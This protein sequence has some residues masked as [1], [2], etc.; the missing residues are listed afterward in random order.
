MLNPTEPGRRPA[1]ARSRN[2]SAAPAAGADADRG[3]YRYPTIYGD[4]LVFVCEDDLWSVPT[5]GGTARRLVTGPGTASFPAFS[6]D[7]RWLVYTSTDDGPAEAYLVP[8]EGGTPRRLSYFGTTTQSVGWRPDGRS[9]VVTSNWRLP[10]ARSFQLWELPTGGAPPRALPV[11]PARAISYQPDGPGVVIGRNSGDPAR[12]KRYRGGT[13]GTLWVDRNGDG[14]FAPLIKLA[15]NLAS[16][17]WLGRRI[18]FL[19]D[20][21]GHGNLYS[22]TPTGRGLK[23]HTDHEDYYVRFPSTDGRRIAYHRGADLHVFDP[24]TDGCHQVDVRTLS[25]RHG[26]GRRFV[27]AGRFLE[28]YDLHP[29]GHSV[30]VVSRGGVYT[31]PLWEGAAVCVGHGADARHRLARWLPDGRHVLAVTDTTGEETLVKLDATGRVAPGATVASDFGRAI[32][33]EVDPQGKFAALTNERFELYL[34]DLKRKRATLIE[35]SEYDRIDGL[36]WSPDG[37]WL[38]YGFYTS[39]RCA[40]LHLLDTRTRATRAITSPGF[41]DLNPAFDPDGKYLYFLSWR[42][43]DPV[44]D[45]HYFDLGFPRGVKP[46]LIPLTRSE[47]SPFDDAA[48]VPRA[49][50]PD[51]GDEPRPGEPPPEPRDADSKDG[52]VAR[53]AIDLAGIE[54]RVVSFPALDGLYEQVAG[55]RGQALF[56][57]FPVEGS[58]DLTW[59]ETEPSADGFLES[60]DYDRQRS[61]LVVD[62]V[63]DFRLAMNAPV[64]AVRSGNRLRVVHANSR[65]DRRPDRDEA[66]RETGW[67]DLGRLRVE[68]Q[69]PAEWRQMFDEAWRLQRDHFWTEDMSK[70]DWQEVRERYRPLLARVTTRSEFSD[71]MWELQGELG[72]SHCYELGGDY[73]PQP[74]WFQ[75]F[76]GADLELNDGTWVIERL[77]RG[78]SWEPKQSSPLSAPGLGIEEGDELLAIDGRPVDAEHSPYERLVNLAG[79]EL[80]LV[81]RTGAGSR[82]KGKGKARAKGARAPRVVAVTALKDETPLRYRDWVECKRDYVHERSNGRVGYVHIPNMGPVG[83]AEFHRY[84]L[85]EVDRDALL[86]DVRWNGG[87]HVSQLLLEKLLR[88]PIGWDKPRWGQPSTYPADAPLGPMVAVTNE[89]AGSDGDIFSHCFKLYKLGPL[90]GK[91][92]WGGVI[93]IWPRHA[94]VDGTVTTQAEFATWF[95][96]V[97]W[98]VEN[99]GA[100]PTIEVECRPQDYAAGTD[101]Q[102]DRALA[103]LDKMLKKRPPKSPRLEQR[104]QLKPGRLPKVARRSKR[105]RVK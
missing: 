12:W 18:Y 17:M 96:D 4:T 33:L 73:Q 91:R 49:P 52:E 25:P 82:S 27:E 37:R 7:G 93:G 8:A 30:A 9:V 60:W 70:V 63:T 65:A 88:Q 41:R 77:P 14:A 11:G 74:R 58:L 54:Q 45:S 46:F 100:E 15:G 1:Q 23:R 90:V 92:T 71:L 105:G 64:V 68:V 51:E 86:I 53:T 38:A 44:Y 85:S 28:S 3:Y 20:H 98:G 87:G 47:H 69:P 104:P 57:S 31:M 40:Q 95:E 89:H 72:T 99:Y 101:P 56:T 97:G 21:E 34:V 16:P 78:D 43:F 2:P 42:L 39:R 80:E 66:S 29:D 62:N 19:S 81:V 32:D 6:P 84:Y 10:F 26:R 79:E 59:Q 83:Y 103:E 48:R 76:L 35:R 22:C 55:V 102:L 61:D 94:L 13:A 75:G 36:S 67:L 50:T 5:S 24:D